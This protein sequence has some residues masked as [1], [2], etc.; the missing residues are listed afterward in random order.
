[1][2]KFT[3]YSRPR[4]S[5]QVEAETHE[6]AIEIYKKNLRTVNEEGTKYIYLIPEG[7]LVERADVSPTVLKEGDKY[8]R[9][10][11]LFDK[12]T[13][14]PADTTYSRKEKISMTCMMF[15]PL[16]L[17]TLVTQKVWT[18]NFSLTIGLIYL[19][20]ITAMSVVGY[21]IWKTPEPTSN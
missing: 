6:Q 1:M 18:L 9:I 3:I 8:S 14:L 11:S 12:D 19:A 4:L 7:T 2:T 10:M 13:W 16:T 21:F 15:L 20:A 5:F 17:L